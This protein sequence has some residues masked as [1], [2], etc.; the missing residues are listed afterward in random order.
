MYVY[1]VIHK[2]HYGPRVRG[3]FSTREQAEE[4]IGPPASTTHKCPTCT[5]EIVTRL[6]TDEWRREQLIIQE[7]VVM[8]LGD[9]GDA[10]FGR[11]KQWH[12]K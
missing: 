10:E 6:H 11:Q 7:W 3:V 12:M 5:T 8:G 4:F 9:P 1:V 2:P